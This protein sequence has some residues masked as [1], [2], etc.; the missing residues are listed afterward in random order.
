MNHTY[1]SMRADVHY[2][3]IPGNC[4]EYSVHCYGTLAAAATAIVVDIMS[5]LCPSGS[6]HTS[7]CAV[8]H[9]QS[10][11]ASTCM[12]C[13][14]GTPKSAK[15]SV[16]LCHWPRP[17]LG[18]PWTQQQQGLPWVWGSDITVINLTKMD[19]GHGQGVIKTKSKVYEGGSRYSAA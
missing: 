3:L 9:T 18:F 13:C 14:C 8:S 2:S 1:K 5:T 16:Q 19:C 4:A 6:A 11:A 10:L 15:L 17:S 12:D 7:P